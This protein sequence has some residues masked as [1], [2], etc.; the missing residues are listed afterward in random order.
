MRFRACARAIFSRDDAPLAKFPPFC[1]LFL[2]LTPFKVT[3]NKYDEASTANSLYPE[4]GALNWLAIEK[5]YSAQGDCTGT[6]I[7][8]LTQLGTN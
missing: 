5:L 8:L 1:V 3:N 7:L 6:C 4:T 2:I